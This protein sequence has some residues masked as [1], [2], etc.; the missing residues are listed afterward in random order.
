MPRADMFGVPDI[1]GW[2]PDFRAGYDQLRG[3]AEELL[4]A[5]PAVVLGDDRAAGQQGSQAATCAQPP[6]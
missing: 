3:Q 5:V 4:V 2:V 1:S 6:R